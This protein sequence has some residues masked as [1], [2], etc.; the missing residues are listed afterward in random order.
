MVKNTDNSSSKINKTANLEVHMQLHQ[1]RFLNQ[2]P[3]V[4]SQ[5]EPPPASSTSVPQVTPLWLIFSFEA[6][7]CNTYFTNKYGLNKKSRGRPY[8]NSQSM[9]ARLKFV[10]QK[11]Q[12]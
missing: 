10:T 8:I 9:I 11:G 5:A 7:T 4:Y 12:Y 1:K 6:I 3:A 2:Q